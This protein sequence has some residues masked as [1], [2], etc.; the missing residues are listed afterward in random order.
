VASAIFTKAAQ[1]WAAMNYE[2]LRHVD[3]QYLAA[4]EATNGVLVNQEGKV[5]RIDGFSLF[6]GTESR[7]KRYASEELLEFWEQHP[8]LTLREYED[9]WTQ[10][11]LE[12][13]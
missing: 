12:Y 7:A 5:D 3:Y 9:Q 2:Y 10:G 11:R 1:D 6:R 8:R 13:Q 4:V